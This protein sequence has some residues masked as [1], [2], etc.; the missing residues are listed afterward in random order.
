VT[1]LGFFFFWCAPYPS[2]VGGASSPINAVG[3]LC[4][5]GK[6]YLFKN[7]VAKILNSVFEACSKGEP[8]G[9]Q[10]DWFFRLEAVDVK[11]SV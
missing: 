3:V 8:G 7:E 11:N 9:M 10:W 4:Y 1:L 2:Q 5:G 6:E